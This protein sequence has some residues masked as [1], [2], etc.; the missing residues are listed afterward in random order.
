MSSNLE[1]ACQDGHIGI[2]TD[3][4]SFS[5]LMLWFVFWFLRGAVLDLW[6]YQAGNIFM[7]SHK[8][9]ISTADER[10][11]IWSMKMYQWESKNTGTQWMCVY[12]LKV[13]FQL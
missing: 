8:Y 5:V 3:S 4:L 9:H 10:H 11:G 6:F 7:L 2:I 1:D 12:G 13:V